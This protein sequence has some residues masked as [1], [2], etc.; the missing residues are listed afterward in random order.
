MDNTKV[1]QKPVE[2]NML[3]IL[4]ELPYCATYLVIPFF[5]PPVEMLSSNRLKLLNWPSR[6]TPF[7]S[8]C[9]ATTFTLIMPVSILTSVATA[10]NDDTLTRSVASIF[11]SF[12]SIV[13]SIIL[14]CSFT[15]QLVKQEH[16]VLSNGQLNFI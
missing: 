2:R 15:Y 12:N 11:F 1:I 7:G 3:Y 5:I 10:F 4:L 16:A 14:I 13:R 8:N 6:A 9:V